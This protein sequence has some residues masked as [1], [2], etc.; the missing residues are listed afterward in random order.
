[1]RSTS[2]LGEN[3]SVPCAHILVPTGRRECN[4]WRFPAC[5]GPPGLFKCRV[6]CSQSFLP[7]ACNRLC[8][9]SCAWKVCMPVNLFCV[10]AKEN[11]R[12][13]NLSRKKKYLLKSAK[14]GKPE[15]KVLASVRPP[16]GWTILWVRG[17]ERVRGAGR[18]QHRSALLC[19]LLQVHLHWRVQTLGS[20][21]LLQ[22]LLFNAGT[23]VV[24]SHPMHFGKSK[25]HSYLA[26]EEYP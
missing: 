10:A 17:K 5:P 4:N 14:T 13:D 9:P 26:L 19:P 23:V 24:C 20:D 8:R 22:G 12:W 6:K 3:V 25:T 11:L 7:T 2:L 1:M 18:E 16:C 21:C 15:L